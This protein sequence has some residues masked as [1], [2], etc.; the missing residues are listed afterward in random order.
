[1]RALTY[2]PTFRG[3]NARAW[4]LQIVRNA[5]YTVLKRRRSPRL[6]AI[7]DVETEHGEGS[8]PQQ[9]HDPADDPEQALIRKRTGTDISR[10]LEQ[11]PVELREI[12]VLRE[13]EDLSYRDIA[14]ITELP[15]GTVM[16]RLWRA[17]Q[18]MAATLPAETR[19]A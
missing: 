11:L 1:M 3:A 10:A 17:R 19:T 9:F 4:L 14:Q 7:S 16:S 5:A 6:V 8:L 13:L 15:T 2:F 12:L 18:L